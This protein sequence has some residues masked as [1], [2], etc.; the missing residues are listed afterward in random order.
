MICAK[1]FGLSLFRHHCRSCGKSSILIFHMIYIA[2]LLIHVTR[3]LTYFHKREGNLVCDACSPCRARVV[4]LPGLGEQRLCKLCFWDQDEVNICR[5]PAVTSKMPILP[6][7]LNRAYP[8][9]SS[10]SQESNVFTPSAGFVLKT[11]NVDTKEKV[12]INVC[13]HQLVPLQDPESSLKKFD[14]IA[15]YTLSRGPRISIDK[16]SNSCCV[17]DIFIASIAIKTIQEKDVASFSLHLFK[18]FEGRYRVT[19]STDY[20]VP[21]IKG[22][23]Q[24]ILTF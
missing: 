24:F 15:P 18:Y 1:A 2:L 20:T 10:P 14:F 19:L 6:S 23:K 22:D 9:P 16:K 13:H 7:V 4:E 11:S 12:F 3:T 8:Q 21:N 5:M 17:Y